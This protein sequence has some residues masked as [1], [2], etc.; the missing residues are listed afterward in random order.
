MIS[1]SPHTTRTEGI[2]SKAVS[3][4]GHALKENIYAEV[5]ESSFPK[6]NLKLDTNMEIIFN[7]NNFSL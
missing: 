1:A 5:S 7:S 2:I 3:T 4:R 6:Y